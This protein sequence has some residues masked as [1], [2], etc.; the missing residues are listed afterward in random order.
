[1]Y[2]SRNK[3]RGIVISLNSFPNSGY[4]DMTDK[5]T[6]S[7]NSGLIAFVNRILR[8]RGINIPTK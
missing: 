5:I 6:N 2:I 3:D 8:I 1:M 4:S 7:K